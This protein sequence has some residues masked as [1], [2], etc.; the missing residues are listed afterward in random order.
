MLNVFLF[1]FSFIYTCTQIKVIAVK[2]LPKIYNYFNIIIAV[3]QHGDFRLSKEISPQPPI[4]SLNSEYRV[5]RSD[6]SQQDSVSPACK[7]ASIFI[8]TTVIILRFQI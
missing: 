7:Y 6:Y 8:P 2:G 1:L 3:T 5:Q 4:G